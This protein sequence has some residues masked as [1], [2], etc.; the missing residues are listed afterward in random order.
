MK[1]KLATVTLLLATAIV[2]ASCDSDE[3]TYKVVEDENHEKNGQSIIFSIKTANGT[4]YYTAD[5]L[6]GDLQENSTAT[7]TLYSQVSRQVF[8]QYAE[9]TLTEKQKSSILA[10]A[11]D[12]VKEFKEDCKTK[13]KEEG[14]DYDVYLENQLKAKGVTTTEELQALYYYN[15]LKAEILDEYI[16]ET[17]HYNYFLDKYLTAYTPFQVKHVLVAANT[18]DTKY[19]D[20]TMTVENARKLLSVMNRFLKG[21]SF[22]SIAEL[23]DDTTSIP[24]GGIMPFNKAQDYVSEFRFATYAQEIFENNTD[25]AKRYSVAADLHIINSDS[26]ASDYVSQDDFTSSSLYSV[27]ENGIG[28]V[29]LSDIMALDKPIDNTMAGAYNYF[30]NGS[31]KEDIELPTIAE[32]PYEMNLDK[33]DDDTGELNPNYYEEYQMERN[34]IFNQYLNTHAVKYIALDDATISNNPN[35]NYIEHNGSKILTDENGNPIF[36]AIAST[37][38]HFMSM[39]WNTYNPVSTSIT[40]PKLS[41]EALASLSK[42]AVKVYNEV[43]DTDITV[44]GDDYYAAIKDR[45][46]FATLINHAYFTLFDT[47]TTNLEDYKYTYIGQNDAYKNKSK[48][49]TNSDDL[50]S[51]ITSYVSSLEYYLYDAIV[52]QEN[53]ELENENWKV[54]F[55]NDDEAGTLA[56]LVEE[57]VTDQISSTDDSFASSVQSAA[58]TYG[59]K[60]AREAEVK[61]SDDNWLW[62]KI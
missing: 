6:L 51:D 36:F 62:E 28:T 25:I 7:A 8:T 30:K 49:T 58:K 10:D 48:L 15:G 45:A 59:Y 38:I 26:D 27:Y 39:V 56:K 1:K 44:T 22:A 53:S 46:D 2:A 34:Q 19:K 16:E 50:L 13:A 12:E 4:E 43:N 9:N 24:N 11:V 37:G 60:L 41:N 20:G 17:D 52:I 35:V 42:I 54:S 5:D 31:V 32:Q 21:D 14:T 23:S 61:D 57:Y 40:S 29:N 33:F 55:T 3:V 47:D 18:S